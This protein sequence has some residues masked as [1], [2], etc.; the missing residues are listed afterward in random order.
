M[1]DQEVIIMWILIFLVF[2]LYV[3]FITMLLLF[4][5]NNTNILILTKLNSPHDHKKTWGKVCEK[6]NFII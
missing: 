2:F 6:T 5:S 1:M 4:V 3:L